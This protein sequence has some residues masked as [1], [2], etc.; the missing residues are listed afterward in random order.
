MPAQYRH[1]KIVGTIGPATES[2]EH[3]KQLIVDGID[4]MRLNM[5]H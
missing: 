1:T 4:V 5:A 2:R 3:L